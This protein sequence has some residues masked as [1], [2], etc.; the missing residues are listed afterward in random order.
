MTIGIDAPFLSAAGSVN[1][2]P[3]AGIILISNKKDPLI[4]EISCTGELIITSVKNG[5][6]HIETYSNLSAAALSISADANTTV[7]IKGELTGTLNNRDTGANFKSM[8]VLNTKI[9]NLNMWMC[10]ELEEL[11]LKNNLLLTTINI[12]DTAS[13]EA[14]DFSDCPALTSI[15]F[16]N[17][18]IAAIDCTNNPNIQDVSG[19]ADHNLKSVNV[20]GC[21]SLAT[22][23]LSL[24]TELKEVNVRGCSAL[25]SLNVNHCNELEVLDIRDCVALTSLSCGYTPDIEKIYLVANNSSVTSQITTAITA[26]AFQKGVVYVNNTDTYYSTVANAA[27]NAGWTIEPLP[28]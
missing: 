28:A 22:L 20:A 8:S 4:K 21:L 15:L 12:T 1:K 16:T 19:E 10:V 9:N 26:N 13:L 3:F 18:S 24:S 23:Y 25:K 5:E 11:K 27:T 14:V 2:T 6:K 17:S 7:R